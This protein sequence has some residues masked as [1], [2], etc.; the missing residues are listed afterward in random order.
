MQ[1]KDLTTSDII[2]CWFE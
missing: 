2:N 1:T